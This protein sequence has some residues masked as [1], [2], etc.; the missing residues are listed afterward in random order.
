[1]RLFR[2][3]EEMGIPQPGSNATFAPITGPDADVTVSIGYLPATD[4]IASWAAAEQTVL[5]VVSGTGSVCGTE[6]EWRTIDSGLAALW[7]VGEEYQVVSESAL[8]GLWITG[9]FD[10]WAAEVTRD[11][12]V[13]DYD[14]A[15][16]RR[17]E[18]ICARIWPSIDDLALR[19]DHVGST[20]VPGLAAKPIIDMD[21]VVSSD[22][23]V[24]PVVARLAEAGYRWRG[25]L[26]IPGREAFHS[27]HED[28]VEHHLYVVVEDNKPHQDHWL[29]RDL[30]RQDPVARDRYAALK[31]QNATRANRDMDL[32]V[33]AKARFV[34][35]LLTRARAE[36]GL[37][38]ATYWEPD[39]SVLDRLG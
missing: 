29:L 23:R 30:L 35:E 3:D 1:M 37:P 17:F 27:N 26:G 11:I 24:Q 5:A 13:V 31:R 19:I 20:S 6:G 12:E 33:A 10:M 22:D 32:Y 18:E 4:S 7:G 2:F 14:P 36:R 25:N 16:P 28:L 8:C 38:T 34:A 39:P 9:D 15:W 21:V